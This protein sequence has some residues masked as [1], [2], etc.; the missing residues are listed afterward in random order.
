MNT[1]ATPTGVA[2]ID[3]HHLGRS[4]IISAFLLHGDEPAI[5]DPGPASTLPAL[6]AGLAEQQLALSDIRHI[7]LTHIHLDH[8]GATGMIVAR[9][10]NVQVHVHTRGAPHLIDPSR[11]LASATQLYGDSMDRLWGRI[12]PVPESAVETLDG[13]ETLNL[14]TRTLRAYNAPGHAKHHLVYFDQ[15]SGTAFIGDNG[16]VRLPNLAFTRPATPPPDINLEQWVETLDLIARLEPQWIALTH[17]GAYADVAF[18]LEDYRERLLRWGEWVRRGIESGTDEAT[19]IA[20]FEAAVAAEAESLDSDKRAILAQQT[21]AMMLSW[22][23]LA[24]YW[25]KQNA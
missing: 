21:G 4:Q 18:H 3:V 6:E 13:G 20:A 24:R 22:R 16:G 12:L 2:T 7:L 8:A 25:Q 1:N 17:F 23:G 9:N 11:L 14:G 15:R 10:P 5:V 19:Q